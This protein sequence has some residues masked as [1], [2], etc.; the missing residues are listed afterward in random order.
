M[1][2][3]VTAPE[4]HLRN[5][6]PPADWSAGSESATDSRQPAGSDEP[7]AHALTFTVR[8]LAGCDDVKSA[9]GFV[10]VPVTTVTL[11]D[12][13][14]VFLFTPVCSA[15]T[16]RPAAMLTPTVHLPLP[17]AVAEPRY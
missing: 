15:V 10:A 16:R 5:P 3:L 9:P 6:R 11:F 1:G 8:A 7:S 2:V 12:N 17:F 14:D 4:A 13:A